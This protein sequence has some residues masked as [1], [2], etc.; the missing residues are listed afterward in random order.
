M[1]DIARLCIIWGVDYVCVRDQYLIPVMIDREGFLREEG[2]RKGIMGKAG[3][4]GTAG[5]LVGIVCEARRL[6]AADKSRAH[7]RPQV[8]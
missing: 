6:K 1:E 2:W 5:R 3:S 7:V 8:L 4:S